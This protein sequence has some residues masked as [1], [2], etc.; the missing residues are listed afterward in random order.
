M[1]T[2]TMIQT[3]DLFQG[4]N[5]DIGVLEGLT[6]EL[7]VALSKIGWITIWILLAG[8]EINRSTGREKTT[9]KFKKWLGNNLKKKGRPMPPGCKKYPILHFTPFTLYPLSCQI[10][11]CECA[12]R[13][14]FR[15]FVATRNNVNISGQGQ[16]WLSIIRKEIRA[17]TFNLQQMFD[18][19]CWCD[20]GSTNGESSV[21]EGLITNMQR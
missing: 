19:Y 13:V 6:V 15:W 7:V 5:L 16:R 3:L 2:R 14:V 1:R 8:S 4:L 17:D 21:Y 10:S 20:D 18:F 11:T 12:H 9:L